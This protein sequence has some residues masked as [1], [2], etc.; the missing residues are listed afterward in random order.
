MAAD[1]PAFD[2]QVPAAEV[3]VLV[4]AREDRARAVVR[5][6]LHPGGIRERLVRYQNRRRPALPAPRPGSNR[7]RSCPA[8]P[9]ATRPSA[10]AATFRV[11]AANFVSHRRCRHRPA[12]PRAPNRPSE[13]R[14]HTSCGFACREPGVELRPRACAALVD[15]LSSPA[16]PASPALPSAANPRRAAP[17]R[18]GGVSFT[19]PSIA[20]CVVLLKNAASS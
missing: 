1:S 10:A 12:A 7:Q 4:H 19:L 6:Q 3:V 13:S 2:P 15:A 14:R 11:L 9:A 18:S 5:R 16:G 17:P 8:C 20:F